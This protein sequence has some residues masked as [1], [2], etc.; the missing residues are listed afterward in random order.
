MNLTL[1]LISI[2]FAALP[3]TSTYKLNSYGFGS[4][5]TAGSSTSTYSLEGIT[6]EIVGASSST[7]TYTVKPGFIETQQGNVPKVTLDNNSGVYY[8]KLHFVIDTQSNPTDATYAL[9]ISTDINFV[10]NVNYIKSD[11]TVGSTLA[12]TDYQTYSQW[13]GASGSNVI[14]LTPGTTYYVRSK[15]T[16]GKYTETGYGPAGSQATA[17]PSITFSLSASDSSNPPTVALGTLA[18]SNPPTVAPVTINLSLDTNAVSGGNVYI[19][20]KNAGLKSPTVAGALINSATA[21]LS[22][23]ASGFGVQKNSI[24]QGSV[25]TLSVINP[26]YGS[27]ANN[28]GLVDTT[29]RSIFTS[30]GPLTGASATVKVIAKATLQTPAASNYSETFTLIAAGTF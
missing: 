20:G 15:V 1:P 8:N 6:G 10:S 24:T 9:Q 17:S 27:T 2:L 21:D 3:A 5:G 19:S 22:S 28:V 25:G 7:S 16:T 29:I 13:G 23:A 4:G 30:S 11:L 18:T 14:G 26:P 12:L